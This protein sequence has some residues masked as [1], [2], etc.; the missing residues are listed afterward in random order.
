MVNRNDGRVLIAMIWVDDDA[1]RES[2]AADGAA[3]ARAAEEIGLRVSAVQ[4]MDLLGA[5]ETA[6]VGGAVSRWAR[7]TWVEG[8][9]IGDVDVAAL[10]RDAVPDQARSRGFAGSYWMADRQTGN[11]LALSFWDGPG[12]L[13]GGGAASRR[14]RRKVEQSIG[15]RIDLVAEYESIGTAVVPA[16]IETASTDDSGHGPIAE[17]LEPDALDEAVPLA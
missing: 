10:H 16:P 2:R 14:R 6:A 1:V 9:S 7:A 15:C 4:T 8:A 5:A 11:G 12:D 17:L 3:R 13:L